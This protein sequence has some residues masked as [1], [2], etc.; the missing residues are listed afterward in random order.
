MK[1][2]RVAGIYGPGDRKKY[3]LKPE[4]AVSFLVFGGHSQDV[5]FRVVQTNGRIISSHLFSRVR[6]GRKWLQSAYMV[7]RIICTPI[8][9][10]VDFWTRFLFGA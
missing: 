2:Y 3:G 4:Y 6:L 9:W 8:L 1:I 7:G 10:A 5:S